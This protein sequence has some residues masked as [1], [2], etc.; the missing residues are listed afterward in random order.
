MFGH[1]RNVPRHEGPRGGNIRIFLN[2]PGW[3]WQIPLPDGIT[4]MGLVAP[5]EEMAAR[6]GTVEDFFRERGRS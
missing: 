5:G 4:S 3:M 1:F 6:D 2:Q